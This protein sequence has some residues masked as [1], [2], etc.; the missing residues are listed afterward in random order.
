MH[1]EECVCGGWEGTACYYKIFY[2]DKMKFK[3]VCSFFGHVTLAQKY[4][5]TILHNA[6]RRG[7][8]SSAYPEGAGGPP[9]PMENHKATGFLSNTGPLPW[10]IVKLRS[11]HSMFCHH[12]LKENVRSD[13]TFWIRAWD[14]Y[15]R[16]FARAFA[17]RLQNASE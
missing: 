12:Q 16:R 11:Q 3:I 9:I 5:L 15:M 17:S 13:K 10:K 8:D 2:N 1:G 4:S 14:F 6:I 7:W